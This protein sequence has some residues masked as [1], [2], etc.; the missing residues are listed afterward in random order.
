MSATT[1]AAPSEA[2]FCAV[3]W[4]MPRPPPVTRATRLSK[5]IRHISSAGATIPRTAGHRALRPAGSAG[6]A[7]APTVS[8]ACQRTFASLGAPEVAMSEPSL[9]SRGAD[10]YQLEDLFSDDE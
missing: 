8:L 2:S 9:L 5:R 6:S 1:T 7:G 3:A 10:Y 4:P